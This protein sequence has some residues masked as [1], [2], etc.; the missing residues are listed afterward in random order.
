MSDLDP[1][2]INRLIAFMRQAQNAGFDFDTVDGQN[3]YRR[4]LEFS[5]RQMERCE[6]VNKE[7][8]KY[9]VLV[10]AGGAVML[11]VAGFWEKVRAAMGS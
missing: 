5:T 6:T 1:A 9:G 11:L 8:T 3:R 7:L 2:T 4:T 10:I